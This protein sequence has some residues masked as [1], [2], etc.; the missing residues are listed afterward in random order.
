MNRN[1]ED[2]LRDD[3]TDRGRPRLLF[4]VDLHRQCD[5]VVFVDSPNE[6]RLQRVREKRG[7]DA[8]ELARREISQWPLDSKREISDYVVSNTADAGFARSQVKQVL[9]RI[10]AMRR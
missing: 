2:D 6:L 10:M 7:W 1:A 3:C 4:E 9:S 5:V 8:A